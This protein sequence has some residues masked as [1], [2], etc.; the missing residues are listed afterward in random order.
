MPN[1]VVLPTREELWQQAAERFVNAA[2]VAVRERGRFSVA[3]SGGATPNGLHA[4]LATKAFR[5]RVSWHDVHVFWGD[6]RCVPPDDA[7]SN[8]RAAYELLLSHVPIPGAKNRKQAEENAGALGW[9]L[10]DAELAALDTAALE[11]K[12]SLQNRFWQHG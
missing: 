5:T 11:G 9:S 4:L 12:R 8:Y 2:A 1:V 10:T 3:L 6:E 7:R